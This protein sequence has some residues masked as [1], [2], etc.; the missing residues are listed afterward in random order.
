MRVK[1]NDAMWLQE[2]AENLMV[3]NSV[4]VCDRMDLDTLRTLMQERIIQADG[5]TRFQRFR[6]RVARRRGLL[7]WELDPAFDIA[8]HI[9]A[10]EVEPTTLDALQA[11]VGEH[12]SIPLPADRPRWEVHLIEHFEAD[13]SAMM[14]RIHH[15]FADGMALVGVM[16][17]LMEGVGTELAGSV[18]PATV[19]KGNRLL[20]A[21]LLP[22][23]AVGV[24]VPRLL[25]RPD[26]HALHGPKLSGKK[27]VAWTAPMDLALVKASKNRLG[28]TVNDLLM[29]T[30]SGAFSRYIARHS[31][32][33]LERLRVSMPVNVRPFDE[34]LVLENR[35]A[36]V[37]LT[38]PAGSLELKARIR[39]VKA[40]MD[41]LKRSGAPIVVYGLQK[42]MLAF[43]PQGLSRALI[44]F[45]ANKCT[46]VVTNVPGPHGEVTLAGRKVRSILFWVPQR[47]DIGIGIS[48][49]SFAGKLQVGVISDVELLPDPQ[50]LVHA[51]EEEFEAWNS[52]G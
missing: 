26:R 23:A 10:P 38:L 32:E 3:I 7:R 9:F 6:C 44:D 33:L 21:L 43:L 12:A 42:A 30:V 13:A 20:Q 31:G 48:I 28:T 40:C 34:P 14:I 25:W 50:D 17:A 8:R 4:I 46:A 41:D 39:A 35:F 22:I 15:S 19:A 36:A 16:F 37:P 49:L 18:R 24:L 29:A 52:L 51:F 1:A 5:G 11:Y 27:R 2:S 47:A 45:L